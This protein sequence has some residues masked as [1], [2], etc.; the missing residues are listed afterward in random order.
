M[1]AGLCCNHYFSA[2]LAPEDMEKARMKRLFVNITVEAMHR[3]AAAFGGPL[4]HLEM[5]TCSNNRQEHAFS[6]KQNAIN[7][8]KD[9]EKG[10]EETRYLSWES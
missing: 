8:P 7:I 3:S 6:A 2:A 10:S 4:K 9:Q 1:P 5:C